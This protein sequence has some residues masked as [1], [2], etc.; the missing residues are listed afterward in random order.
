M[1]TQR[2]R[3]QYQEFVKKH[4]R[5]DW[6]TGTASGAIIGE[7]KT[8]FEDNRV[9]HAFLSYTVCA[10]RIAVASGIQKLYRKSHGPGKWADSTYNEK[11]AYLDWLMKRSPYAPAF[12]YK[13]AKR[14]MT[15][16]AV[17]VTADCCARTMAAAL[18]ASRRIWEHT[19]VLIVFSAL[20]RRGVP[21]SLAYLLGHCAKFSNGKKDGEFI[22]NGAQ[23][24]HCSIDSYALTSGSVKNFITNNRVGDI[25]TYK[26]YK[27]Y[28][29]YG[30][31][32]FGTEGNNFVSFLQ[33]KFPA[34]VNEVVVNNPFAAGKKKAHT[35][36]SAMD[37]M[38][39]WWPNIYKWAGIE[40]K[41]KEAA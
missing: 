37:T 27:C 20:I 22:W 14:A 36:E 8:F 1:T 4:K 32:L 35:F 3:E 10:D 16:L 41:K 34:P 25:D 6:Q 26:N 7:K 28:N 39:E 15:D 18:V 5:D 12:I 29:G 24:G 21:E 38:A 33:S 40:I 2:I 13:D 23:A 17:L 11:V 30:Q 9:C 31:E 19:N